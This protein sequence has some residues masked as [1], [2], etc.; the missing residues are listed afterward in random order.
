MPSGT[1]AYLIKMPE[2][3]SFKIYDFFD[4]RSGEFPDLITRNGV[5]LADGPSLP[6]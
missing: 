2:A 6:A 5:G 4:G 1:L 3:F